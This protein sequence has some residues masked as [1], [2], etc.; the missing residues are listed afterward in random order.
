MKFARI[1]F[2]IAGI[3]GLI[4]LLPLYFLVEKTGR[5]YPPAI[6]H[7]EYYYGF[8][9]AA[10]A[11]QIVFLI[12]A[13]DPV[14]FRPMMLAGVVEKFTYGAAVWIL[15]LQSKTNVMVLTFA[16]IDTLLGILFLVAYARSNTAKMKG[17][18][19]V[20]NRGFEV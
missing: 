8:I 17:D 4:V 1:L 9:G 5:D 11:F 15:Y 12:I 14:R 18:Y 16:S 7:L 20:A 3:Y 2:R 10:I 6:N 19:R 13:Q